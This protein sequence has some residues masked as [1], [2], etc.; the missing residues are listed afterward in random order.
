VPI[1][2]EYLG[3]PYVWAG[4][5]PQG[6]DCS[7]L[8]QYVFAQLGVP[9]PH[10]TV[11]QW[12]D[13]NAESVPESD[14]QAGD[15]VFFNGLDHVGIYIGGGYFVD[16]PHTGANVRI[17]SLSERWYAAKYDGAKRIVGGPLGSSAGSVSTMSFTTGGGS[18]FTSD[19]V[20][21]TH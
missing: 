21:F 10:N 11:A 5:T 12:N 15:L 4:T 2:L 13:P 9:L 17:D 8:V 1:A 19:V 16:A 18:S 3:V 20:Y 6:F 7:G 14:L